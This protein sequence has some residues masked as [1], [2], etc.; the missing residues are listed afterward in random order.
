MPTKVFSWNLALWKGVKTGLGAA[1]IMGP[2]LVQISHD[3]PPAPDSADPTTMWSWL[4]AVAL[5]VV[6]VAWNVIKTKNLPKNPLYTLFSS[7]LVLSVMFSGCATYG[8]SFVDSDGATMR[9]QAT[10][11]VSKI[12]ES[13]ATADYKW[14][15][16][17]AGHWSVGGSASG[18]DSTDALKT[19]EALMGMLQ[20]LQAMKL[21][22]EATDTIAAP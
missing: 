13:M 19:I 6:R 18:M 8:Y 7:F 11:F 9:M 4:V 3:A 16:D 5:V 14:D 15:K 1:A 2:M 12:D 20:Q 10:S 21:A 22:T 17:G